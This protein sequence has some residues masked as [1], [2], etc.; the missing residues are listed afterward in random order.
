MRRSVVWVAAL[1]VFCGCTYRYRPSE[2]AI[3]T[4]RIGLV[5]TGAPVKIVPDLSGRPPQSLFGA[6]TRW[7]ADYD[8]ITASL[9]AQLTKELAKRGVPISDRATRELHVGVQRFSGV[10]NPAMPEGE[11]LVRLSLSDGM[12]KHFSVR[13]DSPTSLERAFD[14]TIARGVTQIASDPDVHHFLAQ[15][16]L[17]AMP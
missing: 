7:T 16:P 2:Y 3:P 1:S 4:E 17:G 13:N 10:A 15:F 12:T 6:G 14:G 9:A 8:E 11:M 5:P